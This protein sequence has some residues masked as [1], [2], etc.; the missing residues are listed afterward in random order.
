MY[1]HEVTIK[2]YSIHKETKIELSP[3]TVFVG[4]N[5]SGKSA[6]FDALLNFSM[7]ARGRIGEAFSR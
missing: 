3:I 6:L 2:N 4:P 1:L 5:G 7:L